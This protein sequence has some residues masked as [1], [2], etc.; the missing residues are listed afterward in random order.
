M[1]MTTGGLNSAVDAKIE[2]HINPNRDRLALALLLSL[3]L[4]VVVVVDHG[5][6]R[7]PF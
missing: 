5:I 2:L 3:L 7:R 4:F 1:T 6:Q